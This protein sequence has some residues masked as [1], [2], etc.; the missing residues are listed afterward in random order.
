MPEGRCNIGLVSVNDLLI[1]VSVKFHICMLLI[2]I[3]A[4]ISWDSEIDY[5]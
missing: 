2:K 4:G 5:H 1:A 3:K